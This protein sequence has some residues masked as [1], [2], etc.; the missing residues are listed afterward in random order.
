MLQ[1]ITVF[2]LL[3]VR[4]KNENR[5]L[6]KLFAL[7]EV[8]EVHSIH[9]NVDVLAKIVLTRDLLSSDAQIISEFVANQIRSLPGVGQFPDVNSRTVDD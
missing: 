7:K 5:L 2:V 1:E 8:R 3:N 4:S 6:Q 9:G